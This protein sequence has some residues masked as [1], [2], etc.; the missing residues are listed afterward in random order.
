MRADWATRG[1]EAVIRVEFAVEQ[2]DPFRVIFVDWL[3]PDLNGVEVARRLR[4]V[5][6]DT[7][8]II[9]LTAY[10]WSD[11]EKEAK[12]AGVTEF[13][14]K[15]LFLS[16][17]RRILTAPYREMEKAEEEKMSL[18]FLLGKRFLLVEDNELNQEIAQTVL[19]E[20]GL[21]VDTADDGTEAVEIIAKMPAGTYDLILMDIQMPV[22]DGY[23]AARTIRAMEDPAKAN[24]PIVAM[25]ANAFEE[26]RQKAFD[27]GMNG[28][29][30]KPIDIPELM[31]TL[32]TI[33]TDS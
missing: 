21:V 31:E 19:E 30:P 29:V 27:A 32:K 1:E 9:I 5:V 13:C 6:G 20:E 23:E 7:A 11:I 15:P 26:D 17:L 12:A 18:Q 3:I 28:H 4:K 16:E 10:D 2:K 8:M 24:I 25:T 33:L 14:S 22:M